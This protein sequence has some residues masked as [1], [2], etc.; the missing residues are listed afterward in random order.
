MAL[1][2]GEVELVC[3]RATLNKNHENN[4]NQS[5]RFL[6]ITFEKTQQLAVELPIFQVLIA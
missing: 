1:K 6:K 5:V 4:K 2:F 3:N